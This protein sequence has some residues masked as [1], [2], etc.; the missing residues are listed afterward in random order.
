[1]PYSETGQLKP[2]PPFDFSKSVDALW[3]FNQML[4]DPPPPS[5]KIMKALTVKDQTIG[6]QVR[7]IG[8]VEAPLLEY[9]LYAKEPLREP[10]KKVILYRIASFLSIEDKITFFKGSRNGSFAYNVYSSKGASTK[11]MERT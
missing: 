6:F 1:M 4:G 7:S 8:L 5:N 10:L 11:P 2:T 9:T 3:S